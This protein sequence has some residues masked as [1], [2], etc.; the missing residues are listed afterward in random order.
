MLSTMQ[1]Q[2]CIPP[3]KKLP[4]ELLD[5]IFSHIDPRTNWYIGADRRATAI[6]EPIA[7][8]DR[9]LRQAYAAARYTTIAFEYTSSRTGSYSGKTLTPYAGHDIEAW[10]LKIEPQH[11][12][13]VR[14][15][16]LV[17]YGSEMLLLFAPD[18]AAT[19]LGMRHERHVW[20][21][22]RDLLLEM[23][24]ARLDIVML[25]GTCPLPCRGAESFTTSN[26]RRLS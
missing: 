15:L 5:A 21:R 23:Q 25:D 17:M 16:R 11:R 9:H 13:L 10:L 14:R 22:V 7:L 4:T 3:L 18:E 8:V 1:S 2:A 6:D 20:T 12:L 24:F 26:V 19:L